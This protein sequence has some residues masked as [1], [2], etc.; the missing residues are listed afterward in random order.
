MYADLPAGAEPDII[1]EQVLKVTLKLR[2]CRATVG[3]CETSQPPSA[4][5]HTF[6]KAPLPCLAFHVA[7][8]MRSA[9]KCTASKAYLGQACCVSD[10]LPPHGI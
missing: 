5:V 10:S 3:R 4:T 1:L 2:D 8:D 7:L 6:V 9:R